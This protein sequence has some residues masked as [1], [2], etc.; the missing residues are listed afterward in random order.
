MSRFIHVGAFCLVSVV[1][2][3]STTTRGEQLVEIDRFVWTDA[4]DRST[5]DATRVYGSPLRA[6]QI[7]LWMQIK[8]SP[9]L[10]EQLRK[11]PDGRI[12]IRHLWQRYDS[13]EVVT[14]LDMPLEVGRT[15]ACEDLPC[16]R[17]QGAC[18]VR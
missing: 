11:S 7:Y 8:G 3:A 17:L 2:L 14:E 9:E 10:L 13:D 6:R 18:R 1:A 12:Q 5:R 4:V 15:R 16:A